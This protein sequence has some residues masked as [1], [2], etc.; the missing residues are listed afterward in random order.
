MRWVKSYGAGEKSGNVDSRT[1]GFEMI[2]ISCIIEI[3]FIEI[4]SS[5]TS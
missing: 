5:A 3:T 4:L 2:V 1:I